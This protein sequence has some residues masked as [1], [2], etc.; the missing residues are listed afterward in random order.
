MAMMANTAFWMPTHL[1]GT[2]FACANV[3]MQAVEASLSLR[4][5]RFVR[6]RRKL[7]GSSV[8]TLF[9]HSAA[10]TAQGLRLDS[11]RVVGGGKVPK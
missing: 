2:N 7:N 1:L 4:S 6:M 11:S 3:R 5:A 9:R 8:R 10:S